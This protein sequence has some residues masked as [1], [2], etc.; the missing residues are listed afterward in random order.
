[1]TFVRR[2]SGVVFLV[3]SWAVAAH[4][5]SQSPAESTFVL[6]RAR[7][8]RFELGMS[9]D[10]VIKLVGRENAR[11]V[12]TFPEGHFQPEL[13]IH[14]P[15]FPAGPAMTAP[16]LQG[17][18]GEFALWGVSVRDP[19]FRTANGLGVGSTVAEIKKFYPSAKIGNIGAD[20]G[21]GVVIQAIG[22]N[23]QVGGTDFTDAARI[24]SVWVI[25]QPV[26]ALRARW[27]PDRK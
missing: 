12:A 9:V 27:C 8:G 20:G 15:A 4:G 5:W 2:R 25:P 13:Q 23:F 11:L 6:E 24:T 16:I 18:C 21:P 7:A 26:P 3:V 22:L 10:D 14:D 19:R 17:P 1:M